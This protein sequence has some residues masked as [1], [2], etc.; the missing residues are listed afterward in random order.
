M[1]KWLWT[2]VSSGGNRMSSEPTIT[3]DEVGKEVVDSSGN[4]VGMVSDVRGG[5]AY[6]DP[7]PGL[8]EQLRGMLDW[9]DADEEDYP[10]ESSRVR[11]ITDDRIELQDM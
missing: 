4:K 11:H 3:D 1:P 7:D 6:V 9:G 2:E 5:T 8:S 10:I